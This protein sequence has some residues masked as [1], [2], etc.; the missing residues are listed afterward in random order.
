M[1]ITK[2]IFPNRRPLSVQIIVKMRKNYS[3]NHQPIPELVDYSSSRTIPFALYR[4]FL[5]YAITNMEVTLTALVKNFVFSFQSQILS[6]SLFLYS[7]PNLFCSNVSWNN[8]LAI[9]RLTFLLTLPNQNNV[10]QSQA[11]FTCPGFNP[12]C[13]CRRILE[14]VG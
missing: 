3:L 10:T 4:N 13:G 6:F 9:L 8:C 7:F 1:A 11:H 14:G 5:G 12:R 2:G